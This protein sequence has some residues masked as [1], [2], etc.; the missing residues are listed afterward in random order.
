MY[1]LYVYATGVRKLSMSH[2]IMAAP[3]FALLVISDCSRMSSL[4]NG[5]RSSSMPTELGELNIKVASAW[6]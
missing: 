5:S 1:T 3:L 2:S 6:C 4:D